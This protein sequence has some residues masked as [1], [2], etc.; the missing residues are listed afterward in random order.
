[1]LIAK[2]NRAFPMAE[3]VGKSRQK[4]R[5][6]VVLSIKP[7]YSDKILTGEKTVELRR[8]FPMAAPHGAIAYIYSTSPVKAMVGT[9]SIRDV[10]R[11]PIEQIWTRFESTAVIERPLFDK[12]F[13]GL[14]DG[15]VIVFDDVK[16]FA[17]PLP[18]VELREKFRFK[19]PQSFR[20]VTPDLKRALEYRAI[21]TVKAPTVV[22]KSRQDG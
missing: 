4:S 22:A 3:A 2:L 5:R 11:L 17:Q 18:L 6:D 14:E 13:E 7:A 9:A 12:Y 16:S 1:M 15:Y 19:P 8:R 21:R 10:L 20:Y